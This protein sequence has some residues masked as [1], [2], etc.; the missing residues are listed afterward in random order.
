MD[1]PLRGGPGGGLRVVDWSRFAATR[2]AYG[3][4]DLTVAAAD[5][6]VHRVQVSGTALRV[7]PALRGQ[8]GLAALHLLVLRVAPLNSS[9]KT[10][11]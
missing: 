9:A 1:V 4:A 8:P 10:R 2:D 7:G 6:T 5:G 3:F 11:R